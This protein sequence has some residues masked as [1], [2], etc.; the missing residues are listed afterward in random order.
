MIFLYILALLIIL[1]STASIH[2]ELFMWIMVLFIAVTTLVRFS[3]LAEES[4]NCVPAHYNS[5]FL[6]ETVSISSNI[7]D[8]EFNLCVNYDNPIHLAE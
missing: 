4:I 3:Q 2:S 1:I 8:D 6:L 7:Q 5:G